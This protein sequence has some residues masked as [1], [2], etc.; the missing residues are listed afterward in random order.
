[1]TRQ[2]W[3][4]KIP[5]T[6]AL[7]ISNKPNHSRTHCSHCNTVRCTS[8]TIPQ[9]NDNNNAN[10]NHWMKM[11]EQHED[12]NSC[13]KEA[14]NRSNNPALTRDLSISARPVFK[15]KENIQRIHYIHR[16]FNYSKHSKRWTQY[17][18]VKNS[19]H[20]DFRFCF[21]FHF[22]FCCHSQENTHEKL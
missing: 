9:N 10:N 13:T 1:M 12:D 17:Y 3:T 7:C 20:S 5:P 16:L 18:Y 14:K 19:S 6:V 15:L 2:H 8:I 11:T 21:H 22:H 4:Y